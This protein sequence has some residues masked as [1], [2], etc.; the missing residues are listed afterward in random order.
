MAETLEILHDG[1]PI[2][3][4]VTEP[5][6]DALSP[7]IQEL[8]KKM[9]PTMR[10]A[11]GVGLAANQVGVDARLFVVDSQDGPIF[12]INP[13]IIERS[14]ETELMDEGCLS[15]PGFFSK[16]KRSTKVTCKSLDENGEE[17]VYDA[18]GLFAQV[19]QHEIDHLNGILFIDLIED[20]DRTKLPIL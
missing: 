17:Q 7:E 15:V 4:K 9:V 16:V 14:K 13:E 8:M 11:N 6:K 10:K 12:F 20:F 3:R 1:A 2:L 5:V 18:E 19:I